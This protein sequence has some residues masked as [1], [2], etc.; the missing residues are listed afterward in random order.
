VEGS[1]EE[2][3]NKGNLSVNSNSQSSKEKEKI[4]ANPEIEAKRGIT[5]SRD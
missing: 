1:R 5:S 2:C 3:N 4:I